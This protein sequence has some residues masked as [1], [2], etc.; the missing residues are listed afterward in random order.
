MILYMRTKRTGLRRAAL[1]GAALAIALGAWWLSEDAS[2][3]EQ[4]KEA[5]ARMPAAAAQQVQVPPPAL[6]E[7]QPVAA[8]PSAGSL[9]HIALGAAPLASAVT[10]MP[11]M[12]EEAATL[13]MPAPAEP[14]LPSASKRDADE[15]D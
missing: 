15:P 4:S 10:A 9:L 11:P 14:Q 6:A 2:P 13:T 1:T 8:V 12:R 5:A 3:P 7:L